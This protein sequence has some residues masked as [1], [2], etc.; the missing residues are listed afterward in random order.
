MQ[1]K[2]WS[3]SFFLKVS[4]EDIAQELSV[5]DNSC[6]GREGNTLRFVIEAENEKSL[7]EK[8]DI[9]IRQL[10]EKHPKGVIIRPPFHLNEEYI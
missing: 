8:T 3:H 9:K 1:K 2:F 7:I 6:E 4:S 5:N 10:M